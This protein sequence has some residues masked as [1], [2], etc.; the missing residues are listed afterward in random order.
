MENTLTNTKTYILTQ[1]RILNFFGDL[2]LEGNL[3]NN[4]DV[5]DGTSISTSNIKN[6]R[7]END[8]VIFFTEHSVYRCALSDYIY[9][10][11]LNFILY[12]NQE[13]NDW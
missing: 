8:Y 9:D 2:M 4:P 6:W 12:L 5:P 11:S 7:F 1:W 3:Y 13:E 10:G